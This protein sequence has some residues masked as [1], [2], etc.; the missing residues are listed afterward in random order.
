MSSSVDAEIW[1]RSLRRLGFTSTRKFVLMGNDAA[2]NYF[3]EQILTTM[4]TPTPL[5]PTITKKSQGT[6]YVFPA[7]IFQNLSQFLG[8]LEKLE[9][10]CDLI[11]Y[12]WNKSIKMHKRKDSG[13]KEVEFPLSFLRLTSIWI[14]RGSINSQ[15]CSKNVQHHP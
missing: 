3:N 9:P 14:F 6:P 12:I 1:S 11:V 15:T 13:F 7:K 2:C 10:L 4:L 5:T 8:F